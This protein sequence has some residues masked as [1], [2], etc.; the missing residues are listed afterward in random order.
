MKTFLLFIFLIITSL[1]TAKVEPPN[2]DFSLDQFADF[3]PG[4]KI[5]DI[6]K[7]YGNKKLSFSNGRF[8]TYQF[9][10]EHIRYK[11]IILVQ[12]E[13]D[14]V[15]DFH[16]RLPHYFLHDVFHQSLI[17]RFGPQDI[18]KKVEESAVYIWKN[19]KGFNHFYSGACTITCFPIFYAVTPPTSPK[20]DYKPL[21][22]RLKEQEGLKEK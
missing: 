15:T 8:K 6:D 12:T 11:F 9:Y 7:K 1:A 19:K 20:G 13:N 16:A 2:Y 10:I 22:S 14:T 18:Y 5:A 4:K 17:N 3:N 21:I